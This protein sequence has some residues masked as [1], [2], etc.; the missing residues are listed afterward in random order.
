MCSTKGVFIVSKQIVKHNYSEQNSH[1]IRLRMRVTTTS[2]RGFLRRKLE[3]K[4]EDI[5]L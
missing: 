1:M 3:T 2:Y 4:S 5:G